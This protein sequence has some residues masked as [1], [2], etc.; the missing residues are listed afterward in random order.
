MMYWFTLKIYHL[1][2]RLVEPT[3]NYLT[4]YIYENV[5]KKWKKGVWNSLELSLETF[6]TFSNGA[7]MTCFTFKNR[8]KTWKN[9]AHI[10]KRQC[11][12]RT[13]FS[14]RQIWPIA[15]QWAVIIRVHSFIL[16]HGKL[17]KHQSLAGVKQVTKLDTIDDE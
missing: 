7:E 16:K 3:I 17:Y 15:G 10:S 8:L 11:A 2:F 6:L 5:Y 9:L 13:T 14:A 1:S 4:F 12:C